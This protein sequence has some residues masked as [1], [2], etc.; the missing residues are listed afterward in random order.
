MRGVAAPPKDSDFHPDF[1]QR[2]VKGRVSGCGSSLTDMVQERAVRR[3]CG[4]SMQA[5][6]KIVSVERDRK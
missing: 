5:C 1:A 3:G 4:S 2:I 6:L